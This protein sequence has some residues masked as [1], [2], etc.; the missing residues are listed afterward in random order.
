M[1][2]RRRELRCIENHE[3]LYELNADYS[4]PKRREERRMKQFL[5][6]TLLGLAIVVGITSLVITVRPPISAP[7]EP[8]TLMKEAP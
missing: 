3:V 6:Y 8:R 7:T 1:Q 5:I 4:G 2:W